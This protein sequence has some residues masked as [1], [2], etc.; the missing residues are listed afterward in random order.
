VLRYFALSTA[1]VLTIAVLATA[2]AN[3]DL[4]RIKI[5]SVVVKVSPKPAPPES[6]SG[7]GGAPFVGDA[8]WAL[9]AL[10]DCLIQTASSTGDLSYVRA[11][12]PHDMQ[13]IPSPATLHYGPCTISLVDGEAYVRRGSDRLRIPPHVQF[14]RSGEQLALLRTI[15]SLAELRLYRQST[16]QR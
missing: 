7:G 4:I 1:L 8:P 14:Y 5:A 3:R 15:G 11:H 12:L 10:P 2:Y 16:L 6:S 13:P 9:S